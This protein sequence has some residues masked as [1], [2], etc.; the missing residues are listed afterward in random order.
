MLGHSSKSRI[1]ELEAGTRKPGAAVIRLLR[2]YLA[3]Y[4]PPD[5]PSADATPPITHLPTSAEV[6]E[7]VGSAIRNGARKPGDIARRSGLGLLTVQEAL[8]VMRERGDPR[9][10]GRSVGR[11]TRRW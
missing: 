6:L 4:R 5:W 1:A 10:A 7:K 3:G 9:L 2:A 11:P 8:A